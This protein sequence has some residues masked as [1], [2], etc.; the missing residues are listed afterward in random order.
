MDITDLREGMLVRD[1]R[2][3]LKVSTVYPTYV[4]VQVLLEGRPSVA[5][6]RTSVRHYA[7]SDVELFF[8]KPT[9]GLLRKMDEVYRTTGRVAS[10]Q[11]AL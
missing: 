3:L 11:E 8:D 2:K 1:G 9:E 10:A 4:T 7:A 6:R 5:P